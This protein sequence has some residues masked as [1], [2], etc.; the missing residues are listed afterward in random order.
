MKFKSII[1]PAIALL[2]SAC[3]QN[4]KE[5]NDA[6]K[7]NPKAAKMGSM[8]LITIPIA[9]MNPTVPLQLAGELKPDQETALF[10]KVQ[11]YVKTIHVDI[12]SQVNKGQILMVLEAPELQAQIANAKAKI[13]SQEAIYTATKA[14]YD[15]MFRA[16]QTKGAIARDALDQIT[17][18]KLSDEASVK[19]ARAAYTEIQDINQYLIIRA[20][21]SGI[22]TSRNTDIGAYVGPM[23]GIPLLVIQNSSKLRLNLSVPEAHVPYVAIGD[24]VNFTVRALPEKNFQATIT[25]KSGTLDLKL[26]SEKFEADF[27]NNDPDLKPFMVAEAKVQLKNSKATFFIPRSAL[28]EGNMGIYVI[29][30]A[31][32][33]AKFIPVKKGRI[34]NDKIEVFGE[35]MESDQLIKMANEEI[36]EGTPIK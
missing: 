31:A 20:P 1:L 3:D 19:A 28:V 25:R 30:N 9:K 2:F 6:T 21:F 33:S 16:N 22:I 10:A 14:N 34:L 15:R 32:G 17:A 35:L 8:P 26:R 12:G 5:N 18:Q 27:V 13:L 4:T 7:E 24:T 23:G 11:S 36:T 29:K